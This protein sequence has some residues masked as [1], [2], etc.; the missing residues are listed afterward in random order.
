MRLQWKLKGYLKSLWMKPK[1]IWINWKL[2]GAHEHCENEL[3]Q[4]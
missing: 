3:K 1:G 4:T 2:F